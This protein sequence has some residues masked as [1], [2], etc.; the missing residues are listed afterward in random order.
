M[1]FAIPADNRVNLKEN[2]KRDKNVDLARELKKTMDFESHSGTV[3]KGLIQ[4]LLDLEMK[5]RVKTIPT[6][7]LL[8]SARILKRVQDTW[9]DL[10]SLRFQWET[11]S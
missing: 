5:G 4:E 10:L 8:K 6:T 7:A 3:N 1:N 2:E 9:E 11:I